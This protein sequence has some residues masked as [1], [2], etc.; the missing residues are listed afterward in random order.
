M[1]KE[2]KNIVAIIIFLMIFLI[3]SIHDNQYFLFFLIFFPYFLIYLF[4]IKNYSSKLFYT[5]FM[6]IILIQWLTLIYFFVIG[7]INL[8]DP[9]FYLAILGFILQILN[10]GYFYYY[11]KEYSHSIWYLLK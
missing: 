5:N 1:K 11:R 3:F 8:N 10:L 7:M 4:R 2:V 6:G 9:V